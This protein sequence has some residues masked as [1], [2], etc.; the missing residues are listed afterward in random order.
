MPAYGSISGNYTNSRQE[1]GMQVNTLLFGTIEVNPAQVIEFP[2]G[3]AGMAGNR[4][5]ILVHEEKQDAPV[6]FTLQSL[7]DPELAL[8]I[9]EPSAIGFNYELALS[10]EELATL[11]QPRPEDVSVMLTLFTRQEGASRELGAGIRAPLIINTEGRLG[12]QKV[13][14]QRRS[15]ITISNLS[16]PV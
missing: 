6:S 13:I 9:I 1:G 3:L 5:F 15:N 16:N 7:D 2:K 10:D 11:G 12:I 4:R 14:E 8:Q